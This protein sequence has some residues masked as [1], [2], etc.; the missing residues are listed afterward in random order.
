MKVS[1]EID[2]FIKLP[3]NKKI[4]AFVDSLSCS[5]LPWESSFDANVLVMVFNGKIFLVVHHSVNPPGTLRSKNSTRLP[6]EI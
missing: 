4:F 6:V 1:T 2:I 3:K 5:I